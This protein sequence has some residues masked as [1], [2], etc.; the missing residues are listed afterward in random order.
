MESG[1]RTTSQ[2]SPTSRLPPPH[3][4]DRPDSPAHRTWPRDHH[5]QQRVNDR[6]TELR[7][8]A[9]RSVF[10]G[11]LEEDDD[12]PNAARTVEIQEFVEGTPMS[13]LLDRG[14]HDLQTNLF[15]QLG[16]LT[17]ALHTI[18]HRGPRWE[19]H[20]WQACGS[21]ADALVP[22]ADATHITAA[23]PSMAT[24]VLPAMRLIEDA[25][26]S[27]PEPDRSIAHSDLHPGNV[28]VDSA[29]A[30]RLIDF[31]LA[32]L[33]EGAW[34]LA[35]RLCWVIY[36]HHAQQQ[37]LP[38]YFERTGADREELAARVWLYTGIH[39]VRTTREFYDGNPVWESSIDGLR[40]WAQAG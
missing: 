8:P 39:L 11:R 10:I 23:D 19:D 36:S 30:V 34:D 38:P 4:Q 16:E 20:D 32:H 29:G 25:L 17:A 22:D 21:W 6:L 13:D 26:S 24:A 28:L 40:R 3:R 12:D 9:P 1:H 35:T 33:W 2:S 14:D 15:R 5:I 18:R 37:F 27:Q 7:F 31:E